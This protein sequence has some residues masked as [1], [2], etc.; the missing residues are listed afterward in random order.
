M[1]DPIIELRHVSKSF[2]LR[3]VNYGMK[4][5]LLHSVKHIKNIVDN[6]RFVALNDIN[7][8]FAGGEA[9]GVY[10]HNGCG[11][12]TLLE[13]IGGILFADSG[14]ITVRGKIGML[15]DVGVGFCGELSGR[16]N[17]MVNGVLQGMSRQEVRAKEEDI[18]E[19]S[20]V[21]QFIDQPLFTYSA[22]MAARLGF[23]IATAMTPEIL[24][25][26]EILAVGDADFR[27][28][29]LERMRTLL[30]DNGTTLLLVSHNMN[31]IRDF[32]HR[33]IRMDHGRI[34]EDGIIV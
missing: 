22:G 17:I 29:G 33:L 31:D 23:S 15:L 26:D 3:N 27:A 21:R 12:T 7:V 6:Q 19:F 20:G 30:R 10:G 5:F 1:S 34:I 2:R 16:E 13:L 4:D 24:L 18:I 8:S 14:K 32:C 11:K 28:K 9:V 25:I